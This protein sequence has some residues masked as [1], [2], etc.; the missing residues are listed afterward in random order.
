VR[1]D[2]GH[3]TVMKGNDDSG[4]SSDDMVGRV[5]KVEMNFL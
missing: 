4:W 1:R 3:G 2:D 5:A